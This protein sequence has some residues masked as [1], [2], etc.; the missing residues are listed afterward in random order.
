MRSDQTARSVTGRRLPGPTATP[1]NYKATK[2]AQRLISYISLLLERRHAFLPL[3][4]LREGLP[5]FSPPPPFTPSSCGRSH[6]VSSLPLLAST[7]QQIAKYAAIMAESPLMLPIYGVKMQ[8]PILDSTRFL[9]PHLAASAPQHHK[10]RR[11]LRICS[12]GYIA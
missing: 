10:P 5:P 9:P 8:R 11:S 1:F 2:G 6:N 7:S 12:S 4:Q 3:A